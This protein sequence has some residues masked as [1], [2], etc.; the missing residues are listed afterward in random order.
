[1]WHRKY[2]NWSS[3][4]MF[5]ATKLRYDSSIATNYSSVCVPPAGCNGKAHYDTLVVKLSTFNI[6][7]LSELLSLFSLISQPHR[8]C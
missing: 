7:Q 8:F 5:K 6:L 3:L 2:S 1:M 4:S